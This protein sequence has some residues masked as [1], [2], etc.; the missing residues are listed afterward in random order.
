MSIEARTRRRRAQV[1]LGGAALALVAA[2]VALAAEAAERWRS[3]D[4][5]PG[6]A[7]PRAP[8]DVPR[9]RSAPS[10]LPQTNL[11]ILTAAETRRLVRYAREVHACLTRNGIEAAAPTT[12][13]RAITVRTVDPVGP[14][15]LV[16]VMASC[17]ARLG[18]PPSPASLQ[19]VDAHTVALSVPKQCLLDPK[20]PAR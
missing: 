11:R 20:L 16:G 2:A 4:V 9:A 18:D 7:A 6:K 15:R 17:A 8:A 10:G 3:D 14:D 12:G 1:V 19:A 5:V 13:A